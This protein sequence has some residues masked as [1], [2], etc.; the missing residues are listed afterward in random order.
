MYLSKQ[1][2]PYFMLAI[3]M[4]FVFNFLPF[5]LLCLYTFKSFHKCLNWTGLQHPALATFMDAFQGY[6]KQ[7]PCTLHL[8]PATFMMA[9]V[10]N[11]IILSGLGI[12]QYHEA[13]SINL[14]VIIILIVITRPFK[15][16]WHNMI[17]LAL[18]SAALICYISV[19]FQIYVCLTVEDHTSWIRFIQVYSSVF[20]PPLYGLTLFIRGIL[21][22]RI[23]NMIFIQLIKTTLEDAPP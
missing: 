2:L 1:H 7:N 21:P 17:T 10:T 15:N 19:V 5:L 23:K 18:F 13:A 9:Q 4:S 8:F 6:Y 3:A 22:A 14:V 11:L 16:R 12:E 20:I